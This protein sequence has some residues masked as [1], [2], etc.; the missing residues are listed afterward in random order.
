MNQRLGRGVHGAELD[1]EQVDHVEKDRGKGSLRSNRRI[2]TRGGEVVSAC[3]SRHGVGSALHGLERVFSMMQ[4][5]VGARSVANVFISRSASQRSW[6]EWSQP[7]RMLSWHERY[8]LPALS[9]I[10]ALRWTRWVST[11]TMSDR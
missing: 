4:Q 9:T 2:S 8:E 3:C 5:Q 10:G 6:S 7:Q 11:C 1:I